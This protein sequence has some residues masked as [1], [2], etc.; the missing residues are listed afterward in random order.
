MATVPAAIATLK[1]LWLEVTKEEQLEDKEHPAGLLLSPFLTALVQDS[2]QSAE[3]YLSSPELWIAFDQLIQKISLVELSLEEVKYNIE[4]IQQKLRTGRWV[5]DKVL[6]LIG[7]AI[8]DFVVLGVDHVTKRVEVLVEFWEG[9]LDFLVS[10]GFMAESIRDNVD[11]RRHRRTG[12]GEGTSG[13]EGGIDGRGGEYGDG[14]FRFLAENEDRMK[15]LGGEN[16]GFLKRTREVRIVDR[17]KFLKL[18]AKE[19]NVIWASL[20]LKMIRSLGEY[21]ASSQGS[22]EGESK[23]WW[24]RALEYRYTLSRVEQHVLAELV[25]EALDQRLSHKG[26]HQPDFALS[27]SGGRIIYALTEAAF[28]RMRQ[29][30]FLGCWFRFNRWVPPPA[31]GPPIKAIEVHMNPGDCWSM[32]GSMTTL[33]VLRF[34][35]EEDKKDGYT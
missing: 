6:R 10:R 31:H 17:S 13:G 3:G 32:M 16:N 8:S 24:L 20:E 12:S 15:G 33:S 5:E 29:T 4:S 19:S 7:Y 14:W 1:E 9:V 2:I 22:S 26:I 18:V 30:K 35:E 11:R 23:R 27:N 28:Y 25:D 21:F 34:K